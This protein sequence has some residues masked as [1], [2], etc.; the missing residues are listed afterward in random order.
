MHE[1]TDKFLKQLRPKKKNF[2]SFLENANIY[3][4]TNPMVF[5]VS[6]SGGGARTIN[7]FGANLN[8]FTSNTG[9]PGSISVTYGFQDYSY[10]QFLANTEN[11][12]FKIGALRLQSDSNPQLQQVINYELFF[13]EGKSITRAIVPFKRLNQY[14]TNAVEMDLSNE[15]YIINGDSQLS[16][17][18]QP[19]ASVTFFIFPSIV[20]SIKILFNEGE[21]A[22]KTDKSFELPL[23]EP[24]LYWNWKDAGIPL[25]RLE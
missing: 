14:I 24:N 12:N 3:S 16:Y 9:L 10:L 19:F 23:N 22:K 5:T 7:L 2:L 13:P 6:N 21:I 11:F 25:G 17:T 15:D 18:M 1:S 4:V 8:R 20:T